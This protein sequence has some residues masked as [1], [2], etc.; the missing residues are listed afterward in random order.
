METYPEQVVSYVPKDVSGSAR[1]NE[2][3]LIFSSTKK[4]FS[5]NDLFSCYFVKY[6]RKINNLKSY[7]TLKLSGDYL[8]FNFYLHYS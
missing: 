2:W 8:F 5:R 4:K 7:Y 6:D 1:L 3:S